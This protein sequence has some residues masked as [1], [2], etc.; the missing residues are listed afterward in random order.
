MVDT[1]RALVRRRDSRE[2]STVHQVQH[3]DS[4]NEDSTYV[5]I[6]TAWFSFSFQA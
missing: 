4:G 1:E 5:Y 3:S 6:S 2:G